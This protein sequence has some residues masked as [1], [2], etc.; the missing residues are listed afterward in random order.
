MSG[1]ILDANATFL[2]ITGYTLNELVGKP[3][4]FLCETSFVTRGQY[5]QLWNQL[6]QQQQ[7]PLILD[8]IRRVGK[9]GKEIWLNAVYTPVMRNGKAIKIMKVATGKCLPEASS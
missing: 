6:Q 5:G 3:H 1:D 4:S 7:G 2:R 9:G 8:D